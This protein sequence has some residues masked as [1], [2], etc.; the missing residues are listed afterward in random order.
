MLSC[1]EKTAS[2]VFGDFLAARIEACTL[3]RREVHLEIAIVYDGNASGIPQDG[4]GNVSELVAANGGGVA[5]HYEYDAFGNT[6][7]SSGSLASENCYR[8][9]T[10]DRDDETGLYYYGYR[11]YDAGVGRWTQR[12]PIGERGGVNLYVNS[13][14]TLVNHYD[15]LGLWDVFAHNELQRYAFADLLTPTALEWMQKSGSDFDNATQNPALSY[16]HGMRAEGE[17]AAYAAGLTLFFIN[18]K[19][20]EARY[21]AD[22]GNCWGGLMIFAQAMHP[23]MD[24]RSPS[25][26]NSFYE[27]EEWK[28]TFSW[29]A[30]LHVPVIGPESY[31]ALALHPEI[32]ELLRT[33][34]REKYQLAFKNCC[35]CR[36]MFEKTK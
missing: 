14:N 31:L 32:K 13:E 10:K 22:R 3:Q 29:G 5:A 23:M 6:V 2:G 30:L 12:D 20:E 9:S 25:H 7:L 26:R 21:E 33:E 34:M 8:F 35:K 1:S 15:S 11:Y 19:I 17:D 28:G 18:S 27:P 36:S 16:L 24:Q 4:N